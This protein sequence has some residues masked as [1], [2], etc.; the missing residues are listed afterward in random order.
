M[1]LQSVPLPMLLLQQR[2]T[3]KTSLIFFKNHFVLKS[4]KHLHYLHIYLFQGF[5]NLF[6]FFSLIHSFFARLTNLFF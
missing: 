5:L 4:V 6:G 1:I 2:S 3:F